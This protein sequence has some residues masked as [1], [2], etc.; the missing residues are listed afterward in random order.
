MQLDTML[1]LDE[2][3]QLPRHDGHRLELS[4]GLLIRQPHPSA[5][6]AAVTARLFEVLTEYA[7]RSRGRAV[8]DA[9][10]L[11]QA[12][13]PTIRQ[14]DVALLAAPQTAEG[15]AD[16]VLRGAPLLAVEITAATA[17]GTRAELLEKVFEYFDAGATAVWVIDLA[18]RTVAA[19][20]NGTAPTIYS[21]TATIDGARTLPGLQC[22]VAK[23]FS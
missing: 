19:F 18:A 8:C 12:E 22:A 20:A 15:S 21:R 23:L 3:A 7:S 4:R 9:A 13:P 11:L 6:H 16:R 14:P 2:Y 5:L 1:T 10:F 17:D